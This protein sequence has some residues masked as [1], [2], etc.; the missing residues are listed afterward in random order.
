MEDNNV[1]IVMQWTNSYT[2]SV[3]KSSVN[4]QLLEL[5]KKSKTMASSS[6]GDPDHASGYDRLA[7]L[8][9]FDETKAGVKGLADSGIKKLPRIF[10]APPHF[11]SRSPSSPAA[12]DE[13]LFPIIDLAPESDPENHNQIV[14][15]I[16][17]AS[18]NWGFFQIVN[19]GIPS[20]LTDEMISAGV[21]GFFNQDVELK[22]QFF[23]RDFGSKKVA[24]ASNFSLYSAPAANW[25]DSISYDMAPNS[26][27]RP[28]EIPACCREIVPGYSEEMT[29]LGD[30]ILALL[31]EALGLGGYYL[32]GIGCG[33]G[34]RLVCHYYPSGCPQPELTLGISP[35]YDLGFVTVVLQDRV[36]GLQVRRGDR[37]FDVPFVD[38]GLVVNIGD[39]LQLISNDRVLVK[40]GAGPRASV[41]A[42]LG[43]KSSRMYGPIKE[44]LSEEN[45]ARYEEITVADFFAY[46]Y[47]KGFDSG[48][49]LQHLKL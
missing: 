2:E 49:I 20:E 22:K 45:P 5:H 24:Y 3:H 23:S 17:Y 32:K 12:D 35:H 37:W 9:A 1:E 31:S 29:R 36:G 39:M 11:L 6:T 18:A 38:G 25:R 19:H 47:K 42:F 44:L 27:P 15:A 34:M 46:S 7:E 21:H 4:K 8:K 48:S 10:H 33:E 41:A 43:G 26:P 28:D 30:R 16:R 40:S 14:E 13:S